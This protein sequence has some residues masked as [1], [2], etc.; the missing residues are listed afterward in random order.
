M[1]VQTA[2]CSWELDDP[3]CCPA[4]ASA[5]PEQRANATA[6]AT[7]VLWALSGRRFGTCPVTV[8]PCRQPCERTL[9]PAFGPYYG[10]GT[11]TP[12]LLDG[13]W[14]NGCG[15]CVTDCSCGPMCEVVLPGPVDTVLEV[16]VDGAVV[17]PADY[18]IYDHR[19]LVRRDT[20][21][22]W[23]YCQDLAAPDTDAGTFSVR[24]TL[25]TPV[26]A[27]GLYAAGIYACEL[28]KACTDG[29]C[30]L[31][32]RV[33]SIVRQGVT[34]ALLDPMEFLEKG[35]TGLY[36]VDAW[37]RAVNPAGLAVGA[38]VHSPDRRPPRRQT[39]P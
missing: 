32:R 37:I 11:F 18:L 30:R 8:R 17:P 13:A 19:A 21:E 23:P 20:G 12:R 25:G 16:K 29:P 33:T 38:R 2:P 6:V 34:Y 5:T 36:E 28:L 3:A 1:S 4:W 26:P 39:W 24:Y 27:A 22:C 35:L 10:G 15:Q 31:P 14:I 9:C 7:E